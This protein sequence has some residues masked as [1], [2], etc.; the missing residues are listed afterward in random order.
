MV[1]S[2]AYEALSV[3][4]SPLVIP[5]SVFVLLGGIALHGLYNIYL[6]PLRAYPGPKLWA[7]TQLVW[8]YYRLTG[9]L[10]W[11]SIDLHEKYGSVVRIA[12]DHLSYTTETAWKTIYGL[13]AVEME[14]NCQAGFSRPG[15]K[16][17]HAILSA[18]KANHSRLRR[19]LAPALSEKSI[20]DHDGMI[21]K[22]VNLLVKKLE[23]RCDEPPVDLNKY[24]EWTTMDLIGD[25]LCG[26]PEGAL[27]QENG[28]RWLDILTQSIQ[29]QVWI[30]ALETYNLVGWREY[31]LPKFR[32]Q[33][34]LENFKI[35]SAK[36]EKRLATNTDRRDILS[37]M[38]GE[39]DRMTPM[40]MRLN[41]ATI[42]GAG[43][44]TTATWLSTNMHSLATNSD[45]Y[46]KL[47][48]EVRAEFASDSEITSERVARLPY[49]AA[50]MKESLRIHC[51][52]PSSTGRFVPPGGETIDGKFVPAGTTV[53]VH[54]HAA[55]HSHS[56]FHRPDD[57][58]PERWLPEAQESSSPFAN[59]RLS[60]VNPFSYGPR[61]CLGIRLTTAE[62]RI[63]LAKLFW[64]FE[65]EIMPESQGWQDT[66]KGTV[67]WHRVPLMCKVKRREA[68]T[69]LTGR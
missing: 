28:G 26:Q 5:L 10:V 33:A 43:T 53:G 56:N 21:V 29:S 12:P 49:L 64:H 48:M 11:K 31:L 45:V 2:L 38:L 57:F 60:V 36:F 22:Y 27:Q 30:Q 54:Q 8:I 69:S 4:Y 63:I 25:L 46:R 58:C 19:I 68:A 37:Y 66:Q 15:L 32:V 13:R 18:D 42:I 6:H 34:A 23:A 39:K 20:A 65:I 9:Q 52:S 51:P 24:F 3:L 16:G 62:T 44:G 1:A 17:V 59:D 35:I 41:A 61:T 50:V 67:A 40:E 7:A 47:A 14:K 55:Y